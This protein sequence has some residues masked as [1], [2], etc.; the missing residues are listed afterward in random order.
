MILQN[1]VKSNK[2]FLCLLQMEAINKFKKMCCFYLFYAL[3]LASKGRIC[4]AI[5]HL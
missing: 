3:V 2:Q 1:H 4:I 5:E